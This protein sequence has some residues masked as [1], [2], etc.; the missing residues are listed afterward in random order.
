M[1]YPSISLF[2]VTIVCLKTIASAVQSS[3]SSSSSS[4][5]STSS[6]SKSIE[7]SSTLLKTHHK[8]ASLLFNL[9]RDNKSADNEAIYVQKRNG[10]KER[11]EGDKVGI[12][13]A[14]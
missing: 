13:F 3:S 1:K 6:L 2:F 11:L 5:L 14:V 4:S 9:N 12:Y 10:S 7:D 8:E